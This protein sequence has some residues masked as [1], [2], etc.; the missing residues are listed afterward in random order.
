M[1][2][3]SL[4][5]DNPLSYLSLIGNLCRGRES[6]DC[7]E[8]GRQRGRGVDVEAGDEHQADQGGE[9]HRGKT[10]ATE[11]FVADFN[12]SCSLSIQ[13]NASIACISTVATLKNSNQQWL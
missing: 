1:V 10:S 13:T 8:R 7:S 4:T 6:F 2:F 11:L 9:G 5:F 12:I 3:S